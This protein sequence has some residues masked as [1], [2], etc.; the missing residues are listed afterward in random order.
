M[1]TEICRKSYWK[2]EFTKCE[3]MITKNCNSFQQQRHR[4][5]GHNGFQHSGWGCVVD[6]TGSSGK[7]GRNQKDAAVS[8]C[9]LS[10]KGFPSVALCCPSLATREEMNDVPGLGLFKCNFMGRSVQ[11]DSPP[12][13]ACASWTEDETTVNKTIPLQTKDS[14]AAV[15]GMWH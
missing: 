2:C 3:H 13:S 4:T 7:T 14:T 1:I 5:H 15:I 6:S 12:F 8:K 11:K 9:P 10:C